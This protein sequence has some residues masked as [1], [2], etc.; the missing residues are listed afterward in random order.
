MPAPPEA[1][2]ILDRLRRHRAELEGMGVRHLSLF[3]SRARG[4]ARTGSDVDLGVAFDEAVRRDALGYVGH[5]QRVADR[6]AAIMGARVDLSDEAMQRE[7]VRRAY[8]AERLR[9]F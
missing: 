2:R 6:L 1:S 3:G 7:P 8:E 5:R 9:A 4:E